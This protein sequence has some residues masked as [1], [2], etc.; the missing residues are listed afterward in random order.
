MMPS[1]L[2]DSSQSIINILIL[3]DKIEI[4]YETSSAARK[5][6]ERSSQ[7]TED[8]GAIEDLIL[9]NFTGRLRIFNHRDSQSLNIET[10]F[11]LVK[12]AKVDIVG[13]SIQS[14][15]S[16]TEVVV[17]SGSVLQ[18]YNVGEDDEVMEEEEDEENPRSFNTKESF[19]LNRK[20]KSDL[21]DASIQSFEPCN[22]IISPSIGVV[23]N[24]DDSQGD[25]VKEGEEKD[26]N[27]KTDDFHWEVG[28]GSILHDL[29]SKT[30]VTIGQLREALDENPQA[31]FQRNELGQTLLHVLSENLPL[32]YSPIMM[33]T[34]NTVGEIIAPRKK[35][36][37]DED[38]VAILLDFGV[39]LITTNPTAMTLCDSYGR[40][41]CLSIL[42][43]WTNRQQLEVLHENK[44]SSYTLRESFSDMNKKRA[45][46]MERD[47]FKNTNPHNENIKSTTKAGSHADFTFGRYS[48]EPDNLTTAFS[49]NSRQVI[50]PKA[51]LSY[52]VRIAMHWISV[53]FNT[54]TFTNYDGVTTS[55]PREFQQ[56]LRNTICHRVVQAIPYFLPTL[57]SIESNPVRKS[58]FKDSS[59][60][61]RLLLEGKLI[62]VQTSSEIKQP[63]FLTMMKQRGIPSQRAIYFLELLS[64]ATI[65]DYGNVPP[66]E[67]QKRKY[68]EY[69]EIEIVERIANPCQTLFP[70][71]STLPEEEID[72]AVLTSL[73]WK[74]I[75]KG[76]NNP[77]VTSF[78]LMGLILPIT[79]LNSFWLF[80][81]QGIPD[82][83]KHAQ[84]Y[85]LTCIACY[86][87]IYFLSQ[88]LA[89][90]SVSRSSM[91]HFL[92]NTW[93]ILHMFSNLMILYSV[94]S[95]IYVRVNP[96][97]PVLN[98]VVVILLYLN[99]FKFIRLINQQ[100]AAFILAMIQCIKNL[101]P[102]LLVLVI[103]LFMFS[104]IITIVAET[105]CG[106]VDNPAGFCSRHPLMKMFDAFMGNATPEDFALNPTMDSYFM[107]FE[108]LCVIVLLNMLIAVVSDA[109]QT[110]MEKSK[111]AFG[112]S[113]VYFLADILSLE[114]FLLSSS[115]NHHTKQNTGTRH[116][117]RC[118]FRWFA[119]YMLSILP[120]A[121][122]YHYI[123]YIPFQ[124]K[125]I[126]ASVPFNFIYFVW[127]IFATFTSIIHLWIV[128]K[129]LIV[130]S[131]KGYHVPI[132]TTI[133]KCIDQIVM[134]VM[135]LLRRVFF[136]QLSV[137]SKRADEE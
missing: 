34:V 5:N 74:I 97:A 89:L 46:S 117:L 24:D 93:N 19:A 32:W 91:K 129:V 17:P 109:Y 69:Y 16:C 71:L 57:L 6:V 126:S 94:V 115:S 118:I 41:P 56:K 68:E 52:A 85:V 134:R 12:K 76:M 21:V 96:I 38:N 130:S 90:N 83:V 40:L 114:E 27:D 103:V 82:S 49:L 137:P 18:N 77:F 59:F 133:I 99:I 107:V 60:V 95:D 33:Q 113:R 105:N 72:R 100:M 28:P 125:N 104:R 22:E 58:I 124:Y 120:F 84:Y 66:D 121:I 136:H 70:P 132:L 80:T 73:L 111:N 92:T 55:W 116:Y 14:S 122:T 1:K 20:D 3:N 25:E 35:M 106:D 8:G 78:G 110:G 63:W 87:L 88:A 101:V 131:M 31:P 26:N 4:Q 30:D 51:K 47:S 36:K 15:K 44:N 53:S 10:S 108:V 65:Y 45:I 43:T 81:A 67:K 48:T 75:E 119:R 2:D 128:F 9:S 86:N 13:A 39:E 7:P 50:F 62:E 135:N 29:C 79:M 64:S 37:R 54:T 98:S 23:Q 102:F 123:D 127:S 42:K 61:R 112:R 11:A